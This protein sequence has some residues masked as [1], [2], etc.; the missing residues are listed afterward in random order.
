M[1]TDTKIELEMCQDLCA[2]YRK[3]VYR[4]RSFNHA[5]IELLRKLADG[6]NVPNVTLDEVCGYAQQALD[7]IDQAKSTQ[8]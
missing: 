6:K 5:L 7:T 4:L 1:N 8:I 3:E 2:Q